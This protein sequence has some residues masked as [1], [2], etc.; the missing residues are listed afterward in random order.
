MVDAVEIVHAGAAEGAVA[1]REAGRLDDMPPR[2]RGRRTA[3]ESFRYFAECRAGKASVSIAAASFSRPAGLAETSADC[4]KAL[5]HAPLRRDSGLSALAAWA[6]T[7]SLHDSMPPL[8]SELPVSLVCCRRP[9]ALAVAPDGCR[10]G[11]G[12][13]HARRF[14]C[15]G[16][17]QTRRRI[18]PWLRTHFRPGHTRRDFLYVATGSVARRGRRLHDSWPLIS[19]T[20]SR[21]S[22]HRRGRPDRGRPDADH[23]RPGGQGL[24]ARQADLHQPPHA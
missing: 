19:Q 8:H 13:R 14:R 7:I 24:L 16:P 5:R 3:A 2:C 10:S 22:D 15:G 9:R 1:D 4:A 23:R 20:Q 17:G 11:F 21:S 6:Q 18:E 12:F